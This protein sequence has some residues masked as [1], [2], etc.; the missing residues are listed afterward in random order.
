MLMYGCAQGV[1]EPSSDVT[2][3]RSGFGE[4]GKASLASVQQAHTGATGVT[5][6]KELVSSAGRS[7]DSAYQFKPVN[8]AAITAGTMSP[9]A[10]RRPNT[11]RIR[12][13]VTPD[14][15]VIMRLEPISTSPPHVNSSSIEKATHNALSDLL[16]AATDLVDPNLATAESKTAT[17]DDELARIPRFSS[18]RIFN[19]TGLPLT[20]FTNERA[21]P[22]ADPALSDVEELFDLREGGARPGERSTV[23]PYENEVCFAALIRLWHLILLSI[24]LI[25]NI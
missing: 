25:F 19:A 23:A 24:C 3:R 14:G 20:Y 11:T 17:T 2:K 4:H 12:N 16:P 15:T 22:V 10:L 9:A 1:L 5:S 21:A 7:G 6:S 18:H 8:A 13:E